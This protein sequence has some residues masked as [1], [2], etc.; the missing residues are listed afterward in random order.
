MFKKIGNFSLVSISFLT[1]IQISFPVAADEPPRTLIGYS[2]EW[3]V[4]PGDTVDFMVNSIN[5]EPY[6]ADLVRVINGESQSIYGDQFKVEY[7]SSSF[8]GSYEGTPQALNLGSYIHVADTG[9]GSTGK[10]H[11]Q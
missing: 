5:G 2:S 9:T 3:S 7:T 8:E 11:G 1:L 4:R 6:K 10:L